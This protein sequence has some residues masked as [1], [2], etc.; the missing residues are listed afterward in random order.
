MKRIILLYSDFQRE[1]I[2]RETLPM[3]LDDLFGVKVEHLSADFPQ[4]NGKLPFNTQIFDYL[5]KYREPTFLLTDR[6]EIGNIF[7]VTAS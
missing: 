5:K 6:V 7:P 1:E 4:C 3:C 2:I